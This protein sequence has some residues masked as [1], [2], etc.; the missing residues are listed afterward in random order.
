MLPH[1]FHVRSRPLED[2]VL[3]VEAHGELDAAG[4]PALGAA[5][6]AA[7][8]E[9]RN[10]VVDLRGLSF[11]DSSGLRELV[12]ARRLLDGLGVGLELV[13]GCRQVRRAFEITRLDGEFR[14]ADGRARTT[15]GSPSRR[16][17]RAASPTGL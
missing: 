16:P 14:W 2:D 8:L 1:G 15:S 4:A 5:L 3:V 13:S 7:A 17:R 10:V 6:K 12:L 9:R 11:M